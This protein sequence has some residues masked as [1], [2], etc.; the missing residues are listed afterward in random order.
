[1][2]S[3]GT[4]SGSGTASVV[5]MFI[6]SKKVGNSPLFIR[7][8]TTNL[9]NCLNF[10]I[11]SYTL[12]PYSC[13]LNI[14]HSES[15]IDYISLWNNNTSQ[16]MLFIE[17]NAIGFPMNDKNG[18]LIQAKIHLF[19]GGAFPTDI[20]MDNNEAKIYFAG[21]RGWIYNE[22]WLRLQGA[23][24]VFDVSGN[25]GFDLR[26]GTDGNGTSGKGLKFIAHGNGS[27]RDCIRILNGGTN[28]PTV[29]IPQGKINIQNLP[30]SSAGLSS[31]D[32]WNNLGVL[33]IV[34]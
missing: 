18:T 22:G 4:I 10:G 6:S 31:G 26:I 16:G 1:M 12:Y 21:S 24:T 28:V 25:D 23:S 30:T 29:E 7:R 17:E 13:D 19:S 34:P 3:S 2:G 11:S 9:S 5:P 8:N 32:I 20:R 33:S 14:N 15:S 27:F